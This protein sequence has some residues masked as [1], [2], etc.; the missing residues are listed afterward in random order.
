MNSVESLKADFEECSN[1]K[2]R[3]LVLETAKIEQYSIKNPKE[4]LVYQ[5]TIKKLSTKLLLHNEHSKSQQNQQKLNEI[6]TSSLDKLRQ[7]KQQLI[8]T[9]EIAKET[10][11][12]LAIQ[13]ESIKNINDN[14]KNT[15]Q[16]LD[17]S[18]AFVRS[19]SRWWRG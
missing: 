7:A 19:M 15:D 12:A 11:Q 16:E 17:K 5:D 3:L 13:K 9:E 6:N 1:D 18:N 14:L 2:E 4:R 10:A 8:Q